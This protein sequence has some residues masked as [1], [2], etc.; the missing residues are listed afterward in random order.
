MRPPFQIL[1]FKYVS[2]ACLAAVCACLFFIGLGRLPLLEPDEGRNAEV[3]RE[4]LESRDWVTPH[5]DHLTYL[6]KP[7]LLFW[8]IAG[9]FEC[10][11]ISEWPARFPSALLALATVLLTWAMARRMSGRQIGLL[12]GIILATSPLFLGFARFVIFDMPLTFFITLAM[13]CLWLASQNSFSRPWLD[14]GAFAAM[15]VATLIKGPVGF[16]LPLITLVVYQALLGRLGELRKLH[17]AVAWIVFLAITLPWFIEVSIRNPFFPKYAFWDESLRRFFSGFHVHRS[18]G[19]WYY[20]P[21]YL[22]G[23]FPWS[24]FLLFAAWNRR[25]RWRA[26]WRERRQA[27]LFLITWAGVVF[28]FFSISR[29]KLP[30]YFLPAVVPLSVLM[31]MVWPD[32][33]QRDAGQTP[34][35]L[36]AGF[37]VMMLLGVLMAGAQ[38]LP[39]R[40][41]EMRLAQKLPAPMLSQFRSSL[42]LGGVLLLALGFLG[43]NMAMRSRKQWVRSLAFAVVALS[44]PLLIL[45]WREPL[46]A[47]F[48]VFSSRQLAQTILASPERNLTLYGYY[49]FRTSLPFYLRRPVGLVTADG[50]EITSNYVLARLK[51]ARKVMLRFDASRGF[52]GEGNKS[53]PQ[54]QAAAPWIREPLLLTGIQLRDLSQSAPGPFLLLARNNEVDQLVRAAGS[55]KPLWSAWRYS[56]WEKQ[57]ETRPKGRETS[58]RLET[59]KWKLE[60]GNSK[61]E[62]DSSL[63]LRLSNLELSVSNF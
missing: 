59:R 38:F 22:V 10:F 26:I 35:W 46:K 34:D 27:E 12:A 32:A 28:V 51:E 60:N 48:N 41:I 24:F 63:P 33:S 20:I 31:A 44:V 3:A 4:M 7:A 6:D 14:T 2:L 42:F 62:A 40:G 61:L 52:G 58:Q 18:A 56:V 37:A 29:S 49:Y 45:R 21:V 17:W 36:A 8:M 15:G 5:Y 54:K 1:N 30:G 50:D 47:Y 57:P 43:R 19:P 25:K 23:V 39:V 16:L 55:I 13:L 9:S 11:G 53:G